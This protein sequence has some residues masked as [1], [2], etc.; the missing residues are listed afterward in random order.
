M[1]KIEVS[2]KEESDHNPNSCGCAKSN[3]SGD[4]TFCIFSLYTD[5]RK[6]ESVRR[7]KVIQNQLMWMRKSNLSGDSTFR[8]FSYT[9]IHKIGVSDKEGSDGGSDLFFSRSVTD[10]E[11]IKHQPVCSLKLYTSMVKL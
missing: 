7:R 1:T 10:H 8:I 4:S 2:E 11:G 5:S 9:Q 3:L 6:S